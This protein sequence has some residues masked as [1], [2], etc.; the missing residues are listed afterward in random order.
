MGEA[1]LWGRGRTHWFYFQTNSTLQFIKTFMPILSSY[2]DRWRES[3]SKCREKD[4]WGMERP[5]IL[6]LNALCCPPHPPSHPPRRLLV[7]TEPRVR[8]LPVLP[9]LIL[10]SVPYAFSCQ[11]V[12]EDL[13]RASSSVSSLLILVPSMEYEVPFVA[14]L[15]ETEHKGNLLVSITTLQGKTA[16]RGHQLMA[17]QRVHVAHSLFPRGGLPSPEAEGPPILRWSVTCDEAWHRRYSGQIPCFRNMRKII[18]RE[19]GN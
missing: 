1:L 12:R 19:W 11:E 10:P 14:W 2:V 4:T 15:A 13:Q 17:P 18:P 5:G 16:S 6:L 7:V 8:T 3:K 9:L